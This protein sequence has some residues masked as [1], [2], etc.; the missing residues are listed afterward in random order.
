MP[1]YHPDYWH[2]GLLERLPE[3][4]PAYKR[5]RSR[6]A[7]DAGGHIFYGDVVRPFLEKLLAQ[8]TENTAKLKHFFDALEHLAEHDDGGLTNLLAVS[9][10][11]GLTPAQIELARTFMGQRVHEISTL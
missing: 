1:T 11:E 5:L 2:E 9:V 4:L 3:L 8:P 6:Y 10:F 7:D